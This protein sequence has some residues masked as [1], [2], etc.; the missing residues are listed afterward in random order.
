VLSSRSPVSVLSSYY[1]LDHGLTTTTTIFEAADA[2]AGDISPSYYESKLRRDFSNETVHNAL[3]D[4]FRPECWNLD[5]YKESN[6]ENGNSRDEEEECDS[7][8]LVMNHPKR[9]RRQQQQRLSFDDE[10]P[11]WNRFLSQNSKSGLS[12]KNEATPLFLQSFSQSMQT[13][14]P[15]L[16]GQILQ[17]SAF[18]SDLGALKGFEL[19][20]GQQDSADTDNI[21]SSIEKIDSFWKETDSRELVSWLRN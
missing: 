5:I 10:F 16:G 1:T 18:A 2:S 9:A 21:M 15:A 17:D 14:S 19:G 12:K 4:E 6:P 11:A 20:G 3:S 8:E 7:D 13:L